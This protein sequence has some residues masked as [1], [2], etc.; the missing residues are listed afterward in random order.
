MA[1]AGRNQPSGVDARGTP[2]VF[3]GVQAI[4]FEGASV[5][6]LPESVRPGE[7]VMALRAVCVPTGRHCQH[8][9]SPT[10]A[11]DRTSPTPPQVRGARPNTQRRGSTLSRPCLRRDVRAP[12][13][14]RCHR[15]A[16]RQA[17]GIR[18]F[19]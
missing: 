6:R 19:L 1:E 4:A 9:A 7:R 12:L 13:Q 18:G 10:A 15:R 17:S 14:S 11:W 5:R 8:A 16:W 2:T 3:S